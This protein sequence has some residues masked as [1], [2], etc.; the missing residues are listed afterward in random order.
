[1]IPN[2]R[3]KHCSLRSG[4]PRQGPSA[5]NKALAWIVGAMIAAPFIGLIG[6]MVLFALR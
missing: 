2:Q 6:L 5:T 4:Q 1:L 3:I